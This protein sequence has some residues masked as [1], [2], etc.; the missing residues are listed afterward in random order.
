MPILFWINSAYNRRVLSFLRHLL[1]P[2]CSTELLESY[3]AVFN[4]TTGEFRVSWET[5]WTKCVLQNYWWVPRCVPHNYWRIPSF[6]RQL[7]NPVCSTGL[8]ES[9]NAVFNRTTGAFQV[10]WEASWT[11]ES[12]TSQPGEED[13]RSP[14]EGQEVGCCKSS[15]KTCFCTA[16][17]VRL[18]QSR[19]RTRTGIWTQLNS[20]Q[21]K[22][23]LHSQYL[24][25]QC[26]SLSSNKYRN[27]I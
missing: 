18:I 10:S 8:L 1:S 25:Q 5:S 12:W 15:W 16:R 11:R 14:E 21:S 26:A 27:V 19:F 3:N 24:R 17:F 6:L 9:S 23:R 4:R 22:L 20:F 7:L 2:V 13:L